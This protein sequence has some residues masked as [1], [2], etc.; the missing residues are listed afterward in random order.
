MRLTILVCLS[1]VSSMS[2]FALWPV[3]LLQLG[4]AWS[5]SGVEIGTIGGAY[6]A[7]YVIA[8]PPFVA[9]T[10]RIDAKNVFI[11]G[12][13]LVASSSLAFSLLAKGFWSTLPIWALS[14]AGLAGIYMPGLQI[15]NTRFEPNF[16]VRIVPYYTACFSL[17][18]AMSFIFMSFCVTRIEAHQVMVFV[19]LSAFGSAGIVAL[20][21]VSVKPNLSE[22]SRPSFLNFK[23]VFSDPI[24][25]AYT[26]SYAGHNFELFGYRSWIFALIVFLGTH[27]PNNIPETT[28]GII[29]ATMTASGILASLFGAKLCLSFSRHKII[30]GIAVLS[31][32]FGIAAGFSLNGPLW[33]ILLLLSLYYFAIMLDS[34][35]LTAGIVEHSD[36]SNRGTVLASYSMFGFVGSVIGPPF[37]G[38]VLDWNG[39]VTDH[40]AWKYA[41]V[42]M[43]LGSLSV[44]FIQ[45]RANQLASSS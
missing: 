25:V 29:L 32:T 36:D 21:V 45:Q 41:L 6:F 20:T 1:L 37:V 5:L 38:L 10:D 24:N 27:K 18:A 23:R 22:K 19:A 34:G 35:G 26:L 4:E 14:G 30:S 16:R 43:A 8:T 17:G 44:F 7:G 31:V 42:T 12:S 33:V 11:C 2:G 39:G 28:A 9:S 40:N 13:L 15:L 3:Y